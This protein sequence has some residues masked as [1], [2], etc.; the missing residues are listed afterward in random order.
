VLAA[1]RGAGERRGGR[2]TSQKPRSGSGNQYRAAAEH[3]VKRGDT[4]TVDIDALAGGTGKG[5]G[6]GSSID[7]YNNDVGQKS[8]INL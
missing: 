4:L 8:A 2:K 1:Q 5:A 3:G 7:M 6:A